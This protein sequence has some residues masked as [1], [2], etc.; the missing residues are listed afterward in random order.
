[1]EVKLINETHDR[2]WFAGSVEFFCF[3]AVMFVILNFACA[4]Q[5]K[6]SQQKDISTSC[7]NRFV[8]VGNNPEIALDTQTGALC[9]TVAADDKNP[10]K[11]ATVPVCSATSNASGFAEWKKKQS[12]SS[13]GAQKAYRGFT[14]TF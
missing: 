11:Y 9:R 14:Y 13:V 8:P 4:D 1:V 12:V 3:L 7:T 6:A 5:Q 10:D 2:R